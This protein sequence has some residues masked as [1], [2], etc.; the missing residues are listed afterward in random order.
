MGPLVLGW[1]VFPLALS[2]LSFVANGVVS[3]WG[4]FGFLYIAFQGVSERVVIGRFG[5]PFDAV[6]RGRAVFMG[7]V[8]GSEVVCKLPI[9][10]RAFVGKFKYI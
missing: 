10:R 7:F 4:A 1:V 9:I 2:F 5:C 8:D 6:S 3:L